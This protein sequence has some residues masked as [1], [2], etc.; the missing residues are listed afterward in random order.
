M[1][2]LMERIHAELGQLSGRHLSISLQ[3]KIFLY[4]TGSS[5]DQKKKGRSFNLSALG[6]VYSDFWRH[7]DSTEYYYTIIMVI[8]TVEIIVKLYGGQ[9]ALL[10]PVEG[11]K[12]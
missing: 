2:S 7:P 5:F 3:V 8:G 12:Q 9:Y 6:R 4:G 1:T 11:C 10:V